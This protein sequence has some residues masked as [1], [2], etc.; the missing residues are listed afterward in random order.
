MMPIFNDKRLSLTG[1]SGQYDLISAD[2][3]MTALVAVRG[4]WAKPACRNDCQTSLGE[5]PV[6]IGRVSRG[7]STRLN[8]PLTIIITRPRAISTIAAGA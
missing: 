1:F 2:V 5:K 4:I 6:M 7:D 8:C 3:A